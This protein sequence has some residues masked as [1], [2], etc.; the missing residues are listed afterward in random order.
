MDKQRMRDL[1]VS[2]FEMVCL[3]I[4]VLPAALVLL[5]AVMTG[6]LFGGIILAALIFVVSAFL[7]GGALTL[8]SIAE[9]TSETVRVLKQVDSELQS[10]SK[11]VE[12]IEKAWRD[13][14]NEAAVNAAISP[15]NA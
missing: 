10:I 2:T 7:A 14:R 5:G 11:G 15:P 3:V 6:N 8:I 13:S 4:V 1:I 9:N 12:R